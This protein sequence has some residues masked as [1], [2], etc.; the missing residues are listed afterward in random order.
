MRQFDNETCTPSVISTHAR[1][2]LSMEP[3]GGAWGLGWLAGRYNSNVV[4]YT[5]ENLN[6]NYIVYKFSKH[7]NL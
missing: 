7:V 1:A 3:M 4:K 2:F 6:N 5:Q